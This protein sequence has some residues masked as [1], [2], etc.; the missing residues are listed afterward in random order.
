MDCMTAAETPPA[1]EIVT[2]ATPPASTT[3]AVMPLVAV[4]SE[5]PLVSSTMV[6]SMVRFGVAP[7]P[8][9]LLTVRMS[10]LRFCPASI[11]EATTGVENRSTAAPFSVKPGLSPVVVR[12]GSSLTGVTVTVDETA[13]VELILSLPPPLRPSSRSDVTVTTRLA[14]PGSSLVLP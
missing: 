9:T 13:S 7:V 11:A 12:V 4:T 3:E 2:V 14:L 6:P 10:V 8:A 5:L 1:F